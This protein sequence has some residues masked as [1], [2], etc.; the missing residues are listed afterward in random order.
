M[1]GL[2]VYTAIIGDGYELPSTPAGDSTPY[3]CFTDQEALNPNGWSIIQV[4]PWFP[5]DEV[6]SAREIKI[7]AHRHLQTVE[8]SIYI[9]PSIQL[10][11]RAS[12]VWRFMLPDDSAD[13]AFFR[14]SFRTTVAEE[15][16]AVLL[17]GLDDASVLAEHYR[18][19]ER[20]EPEILEQQPVISGIVARSHSR[21]PTIDAMERWFSLVC[22]YS[23]RDQLSLLSAL[24][25]SPDFRVR[26]IEEDNHRSPVHVWPVPGYGRPERYVRTLE[27]RS[28]ARVAEFRRKVWPPGVP[29]PSLR[30]WRSRIA[31]MAAAA[32]M[33]RLARLARSLRDL[34]PAP[35]RNVRGEQL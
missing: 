35:F 1:S 21:A 24:R 22:R 30:R 8:R 32:G 2:V 27:D 6:R 14:H 15:F 20:C 23:R 4:D 10:T 12:D 26:I 25:S 11:V 28:D 33:G 29:D 3:Y 7:R 13:A 16:G 17:R 31:E 34:T 18:A 5:A 19:V 9:D